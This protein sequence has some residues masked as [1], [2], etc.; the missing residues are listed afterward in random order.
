MYPVYKPYQP[1]PMRKSDAPTFN[2]PMPSL[3]PQ[4]N[5]QFQVPQQT[6]QFQQPSNVQFQ[7][8][9]TQFQQPP[10]VQFQQPSFP[11]SAPV[12]QSQPSPAVTFA[13]TEPKAIPPPLHEKQSMVNAYDDLLMQTRPKRDLSTA[14]VVVPPKNGP[15]MIA[16]PPPFYNA[17]SVSLGSYALPTSQTSYTTNYAAT[18][19]SMGFTSSANDSQ[20]EMDRP[21][22]PSPPDFTTGDLIAD[23]Q[24]FLQQNSTISVVAPVP[25]LSF[26]S[27]NNGQSAE[28]KHEPSPNLMNAET[29]REHFE[30]DVL[31]D[32]DHVKRV[33]ETIEQ[34]TSSF[35][36]GQFEELEIVA[37]QN[38]GD[39]N[40]ST[41]KTPLITKHSG[42]VAVC[43][44]SGCGF[45]V[46]VTKLIFELTKGQVYDGSSLDQIQKKL[47]ILKA[48]CPSCQKAE[49]QDCSWGWK[50]I[51]L[52]VGGTLFGSNK[53]DDDGANDMGLYKKPPT[54]VMQKNMILKDPTNALQEKP[55]LEQKQQTTDTNTNNSEVEF[56]E[57]KKEDEASQT[58]QTPVI[59]TE[60]KKDSDIKVTDFSFLR[61]SLVTPEFIDLVCQKDGFVCVVQSDSVYPNQIGQTFSTQ[62]DKI[63]NNRTSRRTNVTLSFSNND[64]L[65]LTCNEAN[66]KSYFFV[67]RDDQY[68][69]RKGSLL[70]L[71]DWSK[72]YQI[73]LGQKSVQAI[74]F[75]MEQ[76]YLVCNKLTGIPHEGKMNPNRKDEIFWREC[77]LCELQDYGSNIQ[78]LS[79]WQ[80]VTSL[81][82]YDKLLN[83]P[84]CT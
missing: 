57:T 39:L 80:L 26:A 33:V 66:K 46:D 27:N 47:T 35:W 36:K 34:Y 52:I 72:R 67:K 10:N 50:N 11:F 28:E 74:S 84:L 20:R 64:E 60:E 31:C 30:K 23:A 82:T 53:V 71:E 63:F 5:M 41:L 24:R 51:P 7:Q 69:N 78:H 4:P 6:V 21:A 18:D 70:T 68:L 12:F 37:K 32:E 77:Q 73:L 40:V 45:V 49:L 16:E 42:K 61:S 56:A 13:Q 54:S 19:K 38:G 65:A 81:F 59:Q 29:F 83:Q 8:P 25:Q 79:S 9:Q 55:M 14:P 2:I 76:V 1:S 3:Q 44:C 58:T 17:E 22:A 15:V 43:Q 75:L 48:N 62:T